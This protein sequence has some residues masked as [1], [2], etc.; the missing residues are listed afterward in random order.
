M[1]VADEDV[2]ERSLKE[3]LIFFSIISL[4]TTLVCGIIG[5][6]MSVIYT[7]DSSIS[8]WY[9][10]GGAVF[11]ILLFVFQFVGHM[12]HSRP[13][14]PFYLLGSLGLAIYFYMLLI[15]LFTGLYLLILLI[16]GI[17]FHESPYPE[18]LRYL[19]PFLV[20]FLMIFGLINARNLK[21]NR[22][23]LKILKSGNP[24]KV[25][26]MS[27]IHLGL[28][29]GK[30]RMDAILRTLREERPEIIVIAGDLIDTNP[31]YLE[32]FESFMEE[33]VS[34]APIYA[35]IG[36]HEFYNGMGGSIK[37]M[38]E[39]GVKVLNNRTITDPST[40]LDV[41][42][43]N[44]P[45]AFTD[46]EEYREM[47]LELVKEAMGK[48]AKVLINHQPYH[49]REAAENGLDL[50]LSGHTHAGQIWPFSIATRLAFKEGDRGLYKWMDS[51]MYVCTGTGTWGPPM[52]IGS[53]SEMVIM[54]LSKKEM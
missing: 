4:V 53:R 35:V 26:L 29:V 10:L 21:R 52:R 48:R 33:M 20:T 24:V 27:D 16:I 8:L 40:G 42:G 30:K 34:I 23:E 36:N 50:Q 46:G 18:V 38:E 2:S 9:I 37:W 49:F 22:L 54:N 32:R 1:S 15:S 44:D 7:P 11:S 19:I 13:M 51:Y 5:L 6:Q 39:V 28:L 3:M 47:I 17:P 43:V 45:S 31:D 12:N 25:A 14:M 41:M